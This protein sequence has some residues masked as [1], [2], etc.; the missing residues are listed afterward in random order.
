MTDAAYPVTARTRVRR[1]PKRGVYDRDVVHAILDEA[2]VCHIGTTVGG[3][4]V[5]QPTLPWRIGEE[6]FVH[7]SSKNGLFAA[8]KDGTEACVT[9]TLLD[10]LV[11]A[12]SA[13]HHS[14]NYR[15]VMV[16]GQARLVDDPAE[17]MAA[18]KGMLDKFTPGR[19]DQMREPNATEMKATDVLA[20]PLVEVSAKLRSG[21]P[22]DDAE[23]YGLDIW[24]GVVPLSIV[25][26]E[27]IPD[28]TK[29]P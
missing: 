6:L 8:L 27:P 16:F 4:P 11:L 2:L 24:A 3:S 25:Q 7:G 26:G 10:G 13:F 21:P 22:V 5:V 12:R 14:V 20:F 1:L 15:S 19:W 23:D 28:P 29:A 17:K 18:L 9:V